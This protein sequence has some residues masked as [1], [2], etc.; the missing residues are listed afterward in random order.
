VVVPTGSLQNENGVNLTRHGGA[1]VFDGTNSRWRLGVAPCLEVLVDL[2]DYQGVFRG[3]GPSGFGNVVPAVKWQISPVP[4][5]VDLAVTAGAG[6]PTGAAAIAGRS[7]EPY[8]QLP[9]SVAL[10]SGF[11]VTG[12]DRFLHA[13]RPAQP[14]QQ[15]V[16]RGDRARVPRA[17][18]RV[19]RI[20][21]RLPARRR[22]EPPHQFR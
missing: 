13:G 6:L 2:P 16:D 1:S 20:R 4:G 5:K 3:A 18:V 10:G 11:S 14:L 9:W 19:R 12:M 21:R 15:P 7:V 8:L 22:S 17:L